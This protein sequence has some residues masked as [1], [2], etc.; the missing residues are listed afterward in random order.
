MATIQTLERDAPLSQIIDAI[1]KDGAV[2]VSNF[3]PM[4]TIEEMNHLIQPYNDNDDPDKGHTVP[5]NL[6]D[7][8]EDFTFLQA[9][10]HRVYGLLGKLPNQV[11]DIIQHPV[12]AGIMDAFLSDTS[13]EWIGNMEFPQL[14]SWQ[15]TLAQSFTIL[16]GCKEQPHHRDQRK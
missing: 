7:G 5:E 9:K 6:G 16:P 11:S 10:T 3:L 15:L 4:S 8:L 1:R 14:N 2:I 13:T 12:F